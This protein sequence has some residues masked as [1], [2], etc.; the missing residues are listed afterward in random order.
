MPKENKNQDGKRTNE[1]KL[2]GKK[3]KKLS[4]KKARIDKLQ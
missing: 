1:T 3:D 4:K 2:I